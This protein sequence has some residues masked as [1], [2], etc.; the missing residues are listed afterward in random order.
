MR[1]SKSIRLRSSISL[2]YVSPT[3]LAPLSA[4]GAPRARDG[5]EVP[6]RPSLGTAEGVAEEP[7]PLV[8]RGDPEAALEAGRVPMLPEDGEAE[9]V[10]CV[11]RDAFPRV[12][13]KG[14]QALA[15]LAGRLPGEG[16]REASARRNALVRDEMGDAVG[17]GPGLSGTGSGHDEQR[18]RGD[19]DR[20]PLVRVESGQ[21]IGGAAIRGGPRRDGTAPYPRRDRAKVRVSPLAGVRLPSLWPEPP[22]SQVANR[23]TPRPG[24][25]PPSLRRR[26]MHPA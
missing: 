18:P 15:H 3:S 10:E 16:D 20:E 11:D 21:D 4:G 22:N 24:A 7:D 2:R 14:S 23:A 1:S 8:V 6:P 12:R 19:L 5:R 26:E 13:Q 9:G 25:A 17:E